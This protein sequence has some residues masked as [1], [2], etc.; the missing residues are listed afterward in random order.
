VWFP[1]A[2]DKGDSR[3]VAPRAT[4]EKKV[5]HMV[6]SGG[7]LTPCICQKPE[8]MKQ[9]VNS[10]SQTSARSNILIMVHQFY[11]CTHWCKT[12]KSETVCG[13]VWELCAFST[14]SINLKHS[15][16]AKLKTRQV[17]GWREQSV[18]LWTE[19]YLLTGFVQ[20]SRLSEVRG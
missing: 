20:G 12:L 8:C 9:R 16:K 15:Q 11:K 7:H 5:F 1:G 19:V 3:Q 4:R 14:L 13:G 17:D 6:Q 10:T 18:H 2:C